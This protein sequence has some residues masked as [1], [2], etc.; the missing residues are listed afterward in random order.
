M[1]DTLRLVVMTFPQRWD[2]VAGA[3]DVNVLLVPTGSPLDPLLG[4]ASPAFADHVPAL[5][6][7]IVPS[8]DVFPTSS[9][10]TIVHGT[11]TITDPAA[12]SPSRPN[13][14]KLVNASAAKG[15]TVSG[16]D[17]LTSPSQSAIRKALPQS[18]L[19]VTGA[20]PSGFT[21]TT[22]EFGCA[23]RGHVVHK[24][25]PK[26][27]SIGWGSIISYAL[28]QPLLATQL[29]L[30]YAAR[31]T[32]TDPTILNAGG[33]VFFDFA[34]GDP[35][36][37]GTVPPAAPVRLYAG[38][39]PALTAV[40][41]IF[42]AVIFPVDATGPIDDNATIVAET[43]D[44]GFA[45]IVHVNQPLK[46]D[47]VLGDPSSMPAASDIGVQIGWDD[48]Q[49][50]AWQN[51]QISILNDRLNGKLDAQTPLG[52]LGYRIDVA[53]VTASPPTPAWFS[54]VR[55]TVT[56]PDGFGTF[57]G[58]LTVEPTAVRPTD[59][60]AP[61]AAPAEA[62]LPRYFA[63]WRGGSLTAAEPVLPAMIAGNPITA[64]PDPIGVLLAYG[65]SYAFRVR[66]A[67]LS[68]GGALPSDAPVN[69]DPADVASIDYLR[70]VPPK[71]P[72]VKLSFPAGAGVGY[73][74]YPPAQTGP[75]IPE[76]QALT[77]T[78]PLI[79]FPEVLFTGLG[80]TDADRGAI[81][82][83]L[84]TISK[85]GSGVVG[86]LPDPDVATLQIDVE[87]RTPLHDVA[88][89]GSIDGAFRSLYSTTR[90]FPPLPPGPTPT[91]PGLPLDIAYADAPS[92]LDWNPTQP[93]TGPLVIPR[94]RDVRLTIRA[95]TRD[96]PSYF[97][98]VATIGNSATV[99]IR[100]EL[101][102][103]TALLI[104]PVD[105]S[106]PLR[107]FL[108][109]RPAGVDAPPI[110]TQ[111]AGE[112]GVLVDGLTLSAKPGT[113]IAFGASKGL[114]HAL[115]GD[116]SALTFAAQSELLR[117][118]IAVLVVDMDRDWTWDGLGANKTVSVERDATTVGTLTVVSTLGAAAPSAA[119][120]WDRSRTRLVFFD[121]LDPHESTASGF[122]EALSHTW[123]LSA[124]TVSETGPV[125]G[126]S[127]APVLKPGTVTPPPPAELNNVAQAITLPIA[128]P[129]AQVPTVASVGLALTPFVAGDGYASTSARS[130]S[131]WFEF[132]QPLENAVGDAIFARVLAHGAD[133]LLYNPDP[134]TA[135]DQPA[136][137]PLDIDPELMRVITPA[138]SD[139][140]S[141]LDAMTMLEPASDSNLHF[142]LPLPPGMDPN[143]PDLFGFFTYEFRVGHAGDPHDTRWWST[144]QGRFG[145][146]LRVSGV[147]HPAPPLVCRAGRIRESLNAKTSPAP[148]LPPALA[149]TLE[150]NLT[151]IRASHTLS[152]QEATKLATFVL[153]T[154][155]YA[156]PVLNGRPLVTPTQVPKTV[157]GFFLYAQVVQTDGA[158]N[159]NVLLFQR[160]GTFFN[161]RTDLEGA[162]SLKSSQRDRTGGALFTEIEIEVALKK[163]GLPVDLPLSVLAV[164]FLPGGTAGDISDFN[165][166]SAAAFQEN[167]AG[168]VDLF[169]DVAQRNPD[170]LSLAGNPR[171]IL[172][173]S[174]LVP[175]A[176]FC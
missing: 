133:P 156:T 25:G 167:S 90:T 137:P 37:A 136:E 142:L 150:Q 91:D 122:P 6:A 108:F 17:A 166:P 124:T 115:S 89:D 22:D 88:G 66:L 105:G 29:G 100:A 78:R 125:V 154:A 113:R 23:I 119:P 64:T 161:R 43:Y 106:P 9:D 24:P 162:F 47:G 95:L 59:P 128:I 121:A 168:T 138:E 35:W 19:D 62:W 81:V 104:R 57:D 40:R 174:P 15:V 77:I 96:D 173:V 86:G 87:V 83:Y 74:H 101:R 114:R 36:A 33:W 31:V 18:Y 134:S 94:A 54:L 160:P 99:V 70:T 5:Q 21:A 170:P 52:V 109:Q 38:R 159:R 158:S 50:V 126:V 145:R 141:G 175:V 107:A 14:T 13:F 7:C 8:L 144:A 76:P 169:A 58:E 140:R 1:A 98:P 27:T 32:L 39:L 143:D 131:L 45:Q 2:P 63:H 176:P 68:S 42:A 44:D 110:S 41:Q 60:A 151:A 152:V 139:D 116:N 46:N 82:E 48:E 112:L 67:D 103:E 75:V 16:S 28:R 102:S 120:N 34:A 4:A 79:G 148:D 3:L 164:E 71:A 53:D 10:P 165:G 84:T 123:T 20:S 80:A 111:L 65:R 85:A 147:Q 69:I 93:D 129:P 30:R 130:R 171:R 157:L 163:L 72:G 146:P 117:Q 172:R 56:L 26:A 135:A 97:S 55:S 92:I 155:T 61:N 12:S 49:V 73:G 127:G 11:L 118:W 51:G 153:A 149:N 132:T